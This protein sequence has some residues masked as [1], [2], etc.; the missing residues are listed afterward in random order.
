MK[1]NFNNEKCKVKIGLYANGRLAIQLVDD[2]YRPFATSTVNLPDKELEEGCVYIKDYSEN[3][4]MVEALKDAGIIEEV[5]D[6]EISGFVT[7]PEC[8]LT[9]EFIEKYELKEEV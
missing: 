6:Q 3:E 5:V 9:Q 2:E 1:V 7:I 4:G 8:K